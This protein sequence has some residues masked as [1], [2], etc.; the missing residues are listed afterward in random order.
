MASAAL[1][2]A[3]KPK[4]DQLNADDLIGGPITITITGVKIMLSADQKV[5]VSYQGD[6]GKPYKPSKGMFRLMAQMW[7]ADEALWIGKSL[8]LVRDPTVRFGS[9][10]V[11]GI[12]IHA[13]SD[14]PGGLRYSVT[15]KKGVRKTVQPERLG[16]APVK[17]KSEG[18]PPDENSIARLLA[19]ID[20]AS[21]A[22]RL[23]SIWTHNATRKIRDWLLSNDTDRCDQL[24]DAYNAKL[25]SFTDQ[26]RADH[27]HGDQFDGTDEAPAWKPSVDD[28]TARANAAEHMAEINVIQKQYDL[29]RAVLPDD[30]VAELD[31][32]LS[33][34]RKRIGGAA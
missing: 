15:M 12:R 30:V 18:Q 1:L 14:I 8:T 5:V 25:N 32:V 2:E 13:A 21:D 20:G 4:S 23:N 22:E 17:P 26:G 34:A 6:N 31:D 3:M 16:D 10:E 7:G 27:E 19:A 29:S 24:D 28:W 11:G 33:A 9:D